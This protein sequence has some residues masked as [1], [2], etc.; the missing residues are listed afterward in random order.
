MPKNPLF[1]III[2]T[3]NRAEL[4]GNSI[5]SVVDQ[6]FQDWELI[7]VDD[8]STDNTKQVVESFSDERIRY[9]FKKHEER[10]ITRNTGIEQANGNY[11]CFLDSDDYYLADHLEKHANY[12]TSQDYPEIVLYS[13]SYLEKDKKRIEYPHLGDQPNQVLALW[14]TGYNLLP[15]SFARDII[16]HLRFDPSMDYMED[17]D[18]L[19]HLVKKSTFRTLPDFTQVILEHEGRSISRRFKQNIAVEG[20]RT[21]ECLDQIF[22]R[23]WNFLEQQIDIKTLYSKKQKLARAFLKASIRK[24]DFTNTFFFFKETLFPSINR[25]GNKI[26]K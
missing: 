8:G 24:Q 10:S 14:K 7:V 4:I 5:S 2:P 16:G 6:V 3:Y 9:F 21:L 15:F 23:H 20:K 18:F 13:G 26:G 11:L 22:A 17:L 19:L 25:P 1:S 12:L